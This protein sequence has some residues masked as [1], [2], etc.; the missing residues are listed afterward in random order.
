MVDAE[1]QHMLFILQPPQGGSQK[2]TL[3]QVEGLPG[4]LLNQ[5]LDFILPLALGAALVD[6]PPA[7]SRP[8]LGDLLHWPA[9]HGEEGGSQSLVA[10]Y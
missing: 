4:T 5:P 1:E 3:G 6:R 8:G 7:G 2:W 10:P 9:I